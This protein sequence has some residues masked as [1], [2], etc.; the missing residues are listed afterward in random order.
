[1]TL[2]V[3]ACLLAPAQADPIA[4]TE[5]ALR[6]AAAKVAPS[7][8][9]IETAG[10][11]ELVG[12][13]SAMA[14]GVRKGVGPTTGLVVAADGYIVTSSFNF[15][16]KP[17]D[18]FATVPGRPRAVAKV[19]ATDATRMVTLLKI[20]AKDLPV[21][22]ALPKAEAVIGHWAVALGRTL[23]PDA[24]GPPSMSIGIISALG[25]ITGKAIQTDAKVSP[26]NYGGPLASADGRVY[27]VLVPLS[28]RGDS[29]S[30]GIEWYD[31]GIGF[32]I[33]LED[34]NAVLPRLKKGE[35]L[36]RGVLGVTFKNSAEPYFDPPTIDVVTVDSA[37]AKIGL[38]PGDK[39]VGVDGNAIPHVTALQ[40]ALGPKYAGDTVDLKIV[41]DGKDQSFA[42]VVLGSN[43]AA[44]IQPFLGILPIRDDAEAGVE[45]RFVFPGSPAEKAGLAAGDRI[46]KAPGPRRGPPTAPVPLVPVANRDALAA[47]MLGLAPNTESKFEV[48]KK[49]GKVATVAV[50]LGIVT[51]ELPAD[52]PMPASKGK[53]LA[54]PAG[55][56]EPAPKLEKKDE[57]KDEKKPDDGE[58]KEPETG[59][60]E[61]TNTTLGRQYW[62]Y[63]PKNYDPNVAHGLLLWLHDS[64]SG[65]R[66]AKD[67]VA[68]WERYAESHRCLIVGPRSQSNTGWQASET[69]GVVGD[70][71]EVMKAYTIDRKR[72]VAHGI[73]TGGQMAYYLGFNARS[74][75]RGVAT[76]SAPLGTQPK[77]N[78]PGEPLAFFIVGGDKDPAI[79]AIRDS[80]P[81]LVEKRF[82]VLY[83]E[84]KDFGKQ[85]LD[86]KTFAELQRW[87]DSLDRI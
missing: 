77:E 4:A 44:Y 19:V 33:P 28:P 20:D 83:R 3:A 17:T 39:I 11:A 47:A 55:T 72:V 75:V 45:I 78:V 18:I 76:S 85:Y 74:I 61:R 5:T 46:V 79:Q 66:D 34:I 13:P 73:G 53:A 56:P 87:F 69:E 29:D 36:S 84:L 43:L 40:F 64:G 70:V 62:V 59:L 52:L 71:T 49:D 8:V 25:R 14:G 27:G 80:R 50:K 15:A 31:S 6:A 9:K 7:V 2:F 32:A 67:V 86:E 38:Q 41:R 16:N 51:D 54:K 60:L 58:K 42:K 65:G 10:G 1:M 48:K 82:P 57:K 23:N 21:P 63:V 26:V 35:S 12:G 30:A 81:Q 24:N 37:A 22:A 68:T